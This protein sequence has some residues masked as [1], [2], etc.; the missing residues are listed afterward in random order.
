MLYITTRSNTDTY[1]SHRALSSDT[2]PD[3]GHYVPFRLPQFSVSE[4]RQL[5][6]KSFNQTVADILNLFFSRGLTPWDVDLLIGKAPSKLFSMNHR[7]VIS[8]LW[9]NPGG[10]ETYIIDQIYKNLCTGYKTP[11]AAGDW[12]KTAIRI[13][14][15][16]AVYGQMLQTSVLNPGA[17]YDVV[18]SAEDFMMPMAC[19]YARKMGLPVNTIICSC[20][21]DNNIWDLL[22]RGTL[23]T[24]TTSQ[25]MLL[26][27]EKLVS[28]TLGV[29]EAVSFSAVCDKRRMFSVPEEQLQEL[30]DGFFCA[31]AGAERPASTIN[32]VYRSNSYI[33]EPSAARCIS[34]LQDYRSATGTG[35]ITLVFA[36]KSPLDF[37]D[38]IA[39][40][41]GI[42]S[43]AV[44]EHIN[45]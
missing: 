41:T 37:T 5:K 31:V 22:H 17:D 36:E 24:V 32:S 26:G 43:S 16:F 45:L 42:P 21:N 14:L 35:R 10:S 39:G 23:T 2:A 34:A 13:A 25:K 11:E 3:G 28:S 30:S 44:K 6:E 40:A 19:W 38:V 8:E 18:A 1:T 4:I 27:I 7:I 20:D 12:A 9:H 29:S 33:L 15:L